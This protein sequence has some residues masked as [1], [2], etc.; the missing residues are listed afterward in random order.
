MTGIFNSALQTFIE[1]NRRMNKAFDLAQKSFDSLQKSLDDMR[2]RERLQPVTERAERF[3]TKFKDTVSDIKDSLSDF[4]LTVPFDTETMTWDYE[5]EDGYLSVT[6]WTTDENSDS[7]SSSSY[8]VLLP[9]TCDVS[10]IRGVVNEKDGV[11]NIIVPKVNA[12]K[13]ITRDAKAAAQ[14]G[15]EYA[16]GQLK[17]AAEEFSE[18]MNREDIKT[19]CADT[20]AKRGKTRTAQQG[21][22]RKFSRD[23]N[24]RFA[25]VDK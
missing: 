12:A 1:S 16:W 2:L 7:Q 17:K 10:L 4:N 24:G 14:D 21:H 13:E 18:M 5:V 22:K 15:F 6:V 11:L 3:V 23:S 19:A 9:D 8:R 25:R 20:E